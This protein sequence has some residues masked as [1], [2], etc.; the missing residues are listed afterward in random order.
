MLRSLDKGIFLT[1]K[2]PAFRGGIR[3]FYLF[4]GMGVFS[5]FAVQQAKAAY[6]TLRRTNVCIFVTS[7][8]HSIARGAGVALG[9]HR[10]FL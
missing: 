10:S 1:E 5:Q 3:S 2:R 4:E 7:P 9:F 8:G 6:L